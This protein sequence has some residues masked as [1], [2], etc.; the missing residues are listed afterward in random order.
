MTVFEAQIEDSVIL[1]STVRIPRNVVYRDFVNETVVLNLDR[2]TYHGLNR[3][4]GTMLRALE[5][6]P[7]VRDALTRI[8]SENDWDADLVSRDILALCRTLAEGGLV[9]LDVP[10]Q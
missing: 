7:T 2:G 10:D 3:T 4:A 9:E 5:A 1:D 6:A 8:V